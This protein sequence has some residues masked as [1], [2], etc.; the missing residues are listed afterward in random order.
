MNCQH[1]TNLQEKLGMLTFEV[2]IMINFLLPRETYGGGNKDCLFFL[3]G[4]STN[5]ST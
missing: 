5:N 4:D 3:N 1:Y 2:I